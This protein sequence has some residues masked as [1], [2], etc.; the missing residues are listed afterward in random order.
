[1]GGDFTGPSD[2]AGS[3]KE[4]PDNDHPRA[5]GRT[6]RYHKFQ[7]SGQQASDARRK[8]LPIV[9][10]NQAHRL[11][12]A[13]RSTHSGRSGITRSPAARGLM[14]AGEVKAVVSAGNTGA[15]VAS[16]LFNAKMF[17]PGMRRPGGAD[18][19]LGGLIPTRERAGDGP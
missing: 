18:A 16:A 12:R 13:S 17:L 5:H 19:M 6:G 4:V 10:A 1:M 2:V 7:P 14:A 3:M 8:R 11:G 9:H 15:M